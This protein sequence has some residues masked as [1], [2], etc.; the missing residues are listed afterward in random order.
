M[1]LS[2][3]VD[4][5]DGRYDAAGRRPDQAEWPPHPARVFCALMA[6]A[7]HD[8]HFHAL[9]WLEAAGTPEVWASEEHTTVRRDGYVVA[10][11]TDKKA[12]SQHALGR[13]GRKKTRFSAE[14]ACPR[15]AIVWPTATP[16]PETLGTLSRLARN[17]PY[18]G[19]STSSVVLHVSDAAIP[20]QDEWA[21]FVPARIG[22][23]AEFSFR[24]P[25]QGYVDRLR[26]LHERGDR[27][28]NADQE[29]PYTRPGAVPPEPPARSPFNEMLVFG[30]PAGRVK[31]PGDSL[32]AVT[33]L[34]RAA[35]MARIGTD[36][37]AEI[38][39]HGADTSA[40]AAYLALP[41][42][43]NQH[44]DGRLLGIAVA[45]PEELSRN[46]YARL[47]GALIE[48]PLRRLTTDGGRSL[49][50]EYLSTTALSWG[51]KPERWTAADKGGS[52][53][54]ITATPMMLDRFPGRR[55]A[56]DGILKD[57][58]RS[59]TALGYPDPVEL[60]FSPASMVK[61]ALHRP[62]RDSMPPNRPI[63]PMVHVKVTFD[64]PLI[65]P[66]LLGAMRYLGLG[67]FVPAKEE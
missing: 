40:H 60:E 12:T 18:L 24:A 42:V 15:F 59:L 56:D 41:N 47:W 61:G 54:W 10:N 17:V 38:S 53:T 45:V 34:L 7:V 21:R 49:D 29:V 13:S 22:D 25:Y 8:E 67:L 1:P 3:V 65:G 16:P 55:R 46:A 4:L 32:L 51:L 27:S 57:I 39:G 33:S 50:V 11:A 26:E 23:Y 44:A 31:P 30:F 28:W 5:R 6:S 48:R 66:F 19:R 52:R 62:R 14:P 9:R 36:I 64:R 2:I 63:K 20:M 43:G 35:V 58:H 37:P